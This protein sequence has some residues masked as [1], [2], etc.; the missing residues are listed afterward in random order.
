M[1]T[2]MADDPKKQ[3][4]LIEQKWGPKLAQA[5][6]TGIPNILFERMRALG[7]S[8]LDF[9]IIVILISHWWKPDDRPHPSKARIAA[10][11]GVDPRTVQRRIAA[12]QGVGL[13]KRQER[14]GSPTGSSTN[15]YHFDGLI[16]EATP[17]AEEKIQQQIIARAAKQQ[18]FRRKKPVKVKLAVVPKA[19]PS[20]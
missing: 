16:K 1:E 8:P 11:I 2:H 19:E 9:T 20:T 15:I 5:G 4:G 3:P 6:W 7:L 14:R 18:S 12:M 17:F 13:M 10:M